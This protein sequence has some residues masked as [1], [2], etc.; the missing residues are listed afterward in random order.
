MYFK[1]HIANLF[2]REVDRKEF[3]LTLFAAALLIT[4][5]SGF[6]KNLSNIPMINKN[7]QSPVTSGF[8]K[9]GYGM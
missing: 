5:I 3:I 6:I 4:G 1:T 2:Q 7:D 9:G 8:G